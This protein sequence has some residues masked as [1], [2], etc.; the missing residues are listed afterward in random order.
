MRKVIVTIIC[1]ALSF[2]ASAQPSCKG[3]KEDFAQRIESEKIAFYTQA[4]DLTPAEAKEFWPVYDA[5]EKE[6]RTLEKAVRESFKNLNSAIKEGKGDK[7]T[8]ALLDKYLKACDANVNLHAR[9]IDK[10]KAVL[11]SAK[12]AKFFTAQENFRRHM[13]KNM[14][15]GDGMQHKRK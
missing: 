7:E 5:I 6:Q 1:A 14:R 2:A 4:L 12:V 10:Y 8:E 15:H 9:S 3:Q 13:F 11:P